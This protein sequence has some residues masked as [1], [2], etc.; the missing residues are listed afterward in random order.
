MKSFL[1]IKFGEEFHSPD[2]P[3]QDFL[4]MCFNVDLSKQQGEEI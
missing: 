2:S 3:K 1:E 4:E